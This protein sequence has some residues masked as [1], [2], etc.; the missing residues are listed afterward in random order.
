Q[1]DAFNPLPWALRLPSYAAVNLEAQG[2]LTEAALKDVEAYALGEYLSVFAAPPGDTEREGRLYATVAKL[3][4]LP[5]ALVRRWEGTVPLGVFL[6]EL[7]HDEKA[8]ISRYD[9]SVAGI[10]PAPWSSSPQS[11]DPILEGT[12][13]P[14]S[15]AF[16]TYARD[17]LHYKVD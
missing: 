8:L 2:R 13:A 15:S 12:R 10:D 3:T 9:G 6:K 11:G 5:E 16:I 14:I 7:R 1:E 17:E 4:G